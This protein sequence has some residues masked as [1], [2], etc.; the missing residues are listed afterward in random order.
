MFLCPPLKWVTLSIPIVKSFHTSISYLNFSLHTTMSIE[1][2]WG[3][4]GALRGPF[5]AWNSKQNTSIHQISLYL[6]LKW[7]TLSIPIVKSSH[8]KIFYLYFSWQ[9]R[10]SIKNHRKPSR[11]PGALQNQKTA[12]TCLKSSDIPLY[13]FNGSNTQFLHSEIIP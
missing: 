10:L 9:H 11:A 7:V 8:S 13:T 5:S 3:P 2:R 12:K 1:N 6:P 4:S